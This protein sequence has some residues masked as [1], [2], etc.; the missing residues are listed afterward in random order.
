MTPIWTICFHAYRDA[1]PDPEASVNFMPDMWAKIEAREASSTIFSRMAK[2]LVTAALGAS[3]VM[4]LCCRRPLPAISPRSAPSRRIAIS[5][6]SRLTT[7]RI[8]NRSRW[9]EFPSWSNSKIDMPRT[10]PER[11]SLS[12]A[13]FRQRNPGGSCFHAALCGE[14]SGCARSPPAHHGGIH[15]SLY[16]RDAAEGRRER[17]AGRRRSQKS[18]ATRRRSIDDLRHEERPQRD[19]IQQDQ[20]DAIRA[21]LTDAQKPAY[22][23]WRAERLKARRTRDKTKPRPHQS[24]PPTSPDISPAR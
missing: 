21:V 7:F 15:A 8:S 18:W 3:V 24:R 5:R 16:G 6:R 22:E 10:T 14:G 13:G 4:G 17:R 9:N 19:R 2:T 1:C 11:H 12:G 20:I 23:A